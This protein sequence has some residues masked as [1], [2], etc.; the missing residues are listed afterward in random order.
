MGVKDERLL[1]GQLGRGEFARFETPIEQAGNSQC[2]NFK[3]QTP[4][5]KKKNNFDG[6]CWCGK[7]N[8]G[9]VLAVRDMSDGKKR[10]KSVN[11]ALK[12]VQNRSEAFWSEKNSRELEIA[13]QELLFS[14]I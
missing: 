8:T 5:P 10:S 6:W 9:V 1:E 11:K 7:K 13:V 2:W 4:N 3:L 14:W 12:K